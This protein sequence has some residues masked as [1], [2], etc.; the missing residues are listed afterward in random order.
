[1]SRTDLLAAGDPAR[2]ATP[3]HDDGAATVAPPVMAAIP[4]EALAL[5]PGL[6]REAGHDL[7]L[8]GRECAWP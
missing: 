4:R 3:F 6:H 8:L 7:A 1:M 2:P 5:L